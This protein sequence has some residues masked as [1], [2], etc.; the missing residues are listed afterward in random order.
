MNKLLKEA[1]SLFLVFAFAAA[2][3]IPQTGVKTEFPVKREETPATWERDGWNQIAKSRQIKFKRRKAKNIILFLG[4]GMSIPTLAAARI[5]EGQL[6]GESGEENLLSFEQFPFSALS[7]TYDVNQQTPD[8]APTMSAIMTGIKTVDG[9]ISVNQNILNGDKTGRQ[10]W[11]KTLLEYAEEDGKST[12]VIST[13]RL[14]HATPAACYAH[15][16]ER[17]WES[18]ADIFE[19]DKA[20]YDAKYPDIARQLI[21]FPYGDGLEVA[22]GGGRTYFTPNTM[23]DPEYPENKGKRL[24]GRD[25]TAEWTAKYK[26]SN[27]VW[28]KA[29]FDAIDPKKTDHLFGLFQPSHLLYEQDRAKDKAGEPS[30]SDMTSKAIDILSKNKK[31]YFLMIEAGKIDH[32]HHDG[33]AYRALT[34]AIELSNSVRTAKNKINLDETLIIVTAD[35]SHTMTFSGYP[36]RGNNIMGLVREPGSDGKPKSEPALDKDKKPY[37]TLGYANG[38]GAVSE[39][40][41]LTDQEVTDPNYRQEAAISK[42][43]ETHGGDDVAIFADGVNAWM[44]RGSMEQN[45]IFYV[46]ADAFRIKK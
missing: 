14:T 1:T 21:E 42:M 20:A 31:G 17:G 22:L 3:V 16:P 27:Y 4:D 25:L 33:N 6:R 2:S 26:N 39:R 45:W 19:S 37:T 10:H 24:D 12:G 9:A 13:A 29:Q 32:A 41:I 38:P 23:E 40:K 46:M 30:L 28:N 36:S 7:R 5:L 11:R 15:S 43:S 44:F 8:S 35:H 34:E 18:D